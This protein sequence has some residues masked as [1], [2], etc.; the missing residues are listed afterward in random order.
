MSAMSLLTY[1]TL[2][3]WRCLV[4]RSATP[5]WLR[6]LVLFHLCLC[7]H[8]PCANGASAG[9]ALKQMKV[10]DGFEVSLVASEPEI[11]Q[12][13]SVT[14]DERGRMWVIQYLQYPTPAGLK[15][16]RVDNYLRTT[17]DRLPEPPPHGPKGVDRIT[18]CEL[19]ED[20]RRATKFK[21]FVNGLNLCTGMIHGHGGLFVLQ[22]PY[23]LFYPDK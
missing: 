16:V 10:A 3:G 2:K 7:L 17:Y 5:F 4:A 21:D 8:A 1:A 13:L 14:C 9:E 23:L 6:A 11:R 15:P 12:P 20:R 19:S 18:I 22:A